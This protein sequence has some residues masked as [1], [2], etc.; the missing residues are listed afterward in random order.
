MANVFNTTREL[1]VRY[2]LKG[3]KQG[4]FTKKK[5]DDV[6]D[7]SVALK[8]LDFDRGNVKIDVEPEMKE[9][10]IKQIELDV[11]LFKV[12]EINDYSLLLGIHNLEGGEQDGQEL[13]RRHKDEI[14]DQLEQVLDYDY[15]NILILDNERF[16]KTF[17]ESVDGGILSRDK[18]RIYFVGIIDTLTYYGGKK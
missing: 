5:I 2:D 18:K 16:D 13:Y 10:L 3:S 14:E 4:R 9:A 17:F 11:Q 7:S 12:L 15:G 8:D 1:H 6:V